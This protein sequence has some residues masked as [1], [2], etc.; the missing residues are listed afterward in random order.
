MVKLLVQVTIV[1][2]HEF[3]TIDYAEAA[4]AYASSPILIAV[5]GT[6]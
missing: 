4:H 6:E 2:V 1:L 5:D 3:M